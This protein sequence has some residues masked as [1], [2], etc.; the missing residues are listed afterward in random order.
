MPWELIH[1]LESSVEVIAVVA[2]VL[3]AGLLIAL[4]GLWLLPKILGATAEPLEDPYL[5]D[6]AIPH[7]DDEAH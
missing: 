7:P 1:F 3:I 6:E 4:A 5:D 2:G